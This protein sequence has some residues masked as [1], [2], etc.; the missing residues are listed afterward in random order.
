MTFVNECKMLLHARH[1]ACNPLQKTGG[2]VHSPRFSQGAYQVL[3]LLASL[4]WIGSYFPFH[5]ATGWLKH[6]L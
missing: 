1:G 2:F 6:I 5:A 3:I 4:T